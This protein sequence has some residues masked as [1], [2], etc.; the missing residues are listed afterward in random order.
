M[1][2]TQS[3]CVSAA[4]EAKRNLFSQIALN[5]NCSKYVTAREGDVWSFEFVCGPE[6]M[7]STSKGTVSGNFVSAYTVEMTESDGSMDLS[8]T[9][10]ATR[11]GACPAGV[12]PGTLIDETGK[13]V[14]N[15]LD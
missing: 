7:T 14:T 6:E 1:I 4:T 5:A 9:I 11:T 3:L 12:A 10:Q 2:G 8:R 15:T 13:T